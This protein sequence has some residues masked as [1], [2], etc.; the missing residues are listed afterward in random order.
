MGT[1]CMSICPFVSF[2]KLLKVFLLKYGAMGKIDLH[3]E[4]QV[5][6]I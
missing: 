1:S 4:F 2:P 5:N 6:I 3:G